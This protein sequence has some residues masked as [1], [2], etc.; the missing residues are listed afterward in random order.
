[1]FA[2]PGS[3]LSDRLAGIPT[4]EQRMD[5]VRAVMDAVG[6][7]RAAFFGISEGGPMSILFAASHPQRTAAL[8][9][10]GTYAR[11]MWSPDHPWG[12]TD[13]DMHAIL[14]RME[15]DW[16][17]DANLGLWAPSVANNEEICRAVATY[18][19][20]AAS[21]GAALTVLRL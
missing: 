12:R 15:R 11:R 19:R 5:D 13:A 2:E 4:L 9:L 7:E 14:E 16:G 20:L 1:V 10:Y 8:V 21:P 3:G 18:W 6:S 17:K